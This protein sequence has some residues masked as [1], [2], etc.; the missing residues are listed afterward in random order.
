[1]SQNRKTSD[2]KIFL[3]DLRSLSLLEAYH[4]SVQLFQADSD[5]ELGKLADRIRQRIEQEEELLI[6]PFFF[7]Q[8]EAVLPR[9]SRVELQLK[10]GETRNEMSCFRY[11]AIVH[12]GGEPAADLAPARMEWQSLGNSTALE[13]SLQALGTK[14]ALLI[15]GIPDARLRPEIISIATLADPDEHTV[16]ELQQQIDSDSTQSIQ[17][18]AVYQLAAGVGRELCPAGRNSRLGLERGNDIQIKPGREITETTV[19]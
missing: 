18:E 13:S 8:L 4:T 7:Q 14:D 17:P 2:R 5:T 3:G 19:V 15:T 11:D 9:I 10:R 6:E 16:S 12:L 1:M